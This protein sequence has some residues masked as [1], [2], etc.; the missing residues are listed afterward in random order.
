MMM[1]IALTGSE[2]M[3]GHD[4]KKVFSDVEITALAH[5]SLDVTVLDDVVKKVGEVRPD[6]L[7]HAAAFTDVDRC[8]SEPEKAYLVNG[9]GARNIAMACED[10]KCPVVYISTDYVF[11]GSK[12]NSYDEWDGTNPINVYGVSKQMGERFI[13]M[14]TNRFYIIRTSW[15]YGKNGK[16]FVETIIKLLSEKKSIEVVDDQVGCPTY[17]SDLARTL[18]KIIGKGYGIYHIT[19]TGACSWYEFA[20]AIALKKGLK[21][22]INPITSERFK[23]PARRPANSVLGHTMLRLEGIEEP[24]RWEEAL[25]EYIS[26]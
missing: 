26:L 1:K 14:L 25:D 10:I 8:E 13:S 24:R 20:K 2:G 3:L 5:D 6:L 18:R 15:L 19:N 4:I 11:D 9:I 17:T 23:R 22:E 7:I 16:N 12:R 21:K